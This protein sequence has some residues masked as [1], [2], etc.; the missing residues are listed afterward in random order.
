MSVPIY[1]NPIQLQKK[2]A[3]NLV[4]E[5]KVVHQLSASTL[6]ELD[7]E[8]EPNVNLTVDLNQWINNAFFSI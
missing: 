5:A 6:F 1:Y 8:V 4:C 7:C 2:L 3:V